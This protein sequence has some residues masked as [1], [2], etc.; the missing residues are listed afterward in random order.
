MLGF[1][2]LIVS[3]GEFVSIVSSI[4]NLIL[5]RPRFIAPEDAEYVGMPHMLMEKKL[6]IL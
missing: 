1:V 6:G 4:S 3:L 5:S 2:R